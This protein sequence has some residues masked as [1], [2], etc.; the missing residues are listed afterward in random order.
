[1]QPLQEVG[2]ALSL[3]QPPA[4]HSS[5]T[6]PGLQEQLHS[7]KGSWEASQDDQSRTGS[8]PS[9]S[10]TIHNRFHPFARVFSSMCKTIAKLFCV[11]LAFELISLAWW[12]SQAGADFQ[13]YFLFPLQAQLPRVRWHLAWGSQSTRTSPVLR[14]TSLS[15][16]QTQP[17]P[18]P[19][20]QPSL[21]GRGK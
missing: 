21:L 14:A 9:L 18:L 3:F 13:S 19:K 4:Q 12:S 17:E 10:R 15:T 8:P 11:E 1:M 16:E 20:K 5:L 6:L 2:A 7:T